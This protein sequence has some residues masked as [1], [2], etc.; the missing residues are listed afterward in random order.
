[1]MHSILSINWVNKISVIE[2]AYSS[3]SS[4]GPM[5]KYNKLKPLQI[6]TDPNTAEDNLSKVKGTL[7]QIWK[8]LNI[9][10]FIWK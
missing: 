10:V 2:L 3:V 6:R 4:L 7:I 8:F 5:I 9:F 1:M